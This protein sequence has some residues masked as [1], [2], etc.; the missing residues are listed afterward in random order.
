MVF[1]CNPPTEE[2]EMVMI[3]TQKEIEM[4]KYEYVYCNGSK[5]LTTDYDKKEEYENQKWG[6]VKEQKKEFIKFSE[7][8]GRIIAKHIDSI[9]D[10]QDLIKIVKLIDKTSKQLFG[11]E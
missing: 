11:D 8:L 10:E 7:R 4:D 1:M 2:E 6:L 9:K 5:G 3:K